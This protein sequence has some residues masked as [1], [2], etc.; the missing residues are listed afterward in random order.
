MSFKVSVNNSL[1]LDISQEDISKL[2]LIN[3]STDKYHILHNNMS[4]KAEITSKNFNK[5][6]YSVNVNNNNYNISIKNDLDLL[7]KDM[8]FSLGSTKQIDF[9]SAP[10][11][12]LIL[13]I[14]AKTGQ[15]VK[16]NDPLLILGAM[17]MEN[18]IISPRS[19]RIKSI[20]VTKGDAIEKGQLLVE[21]EKD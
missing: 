16:E 4:Y 21:F 3:I 17:K 8:G 20:S 18:I 11:P 15:E 12:G 5:K 19:G 10:M 7:I 14:I 13:D 6:S 1:E 2:D 9:I